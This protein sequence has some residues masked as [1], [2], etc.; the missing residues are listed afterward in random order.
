M[1]IIDIVNII[2]LGRAASGKSV[3]IRR[4]TTELQGI[5]YDPTNEVEPPTVA[6]DVVSV[7]VTLEG[8]KFELRFWDT[9]GQEKYS[10]LSEAFYRK[11][12]GV[13]QCFDVT[14]ADS[15]D[16][17]DFYYQQIKD[18]C[19]AETTVSLLATKCDRINERVI[20][21]ECG[22]YMAGKNCIDYFETSSFTNQN[23][24]NSVVST[25]RKVIERTQKGYVITKKVEDDH[26][27]YD[28][29]KEKTNSNDK[30]NKR[31]RNK[32]CEC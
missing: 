5:I 25:L 16:G 30:R 6:I 17:V 12:D 19:E 21:T 22:R 13:L 11:A 4:Y 14:D 31:F 32:K 24:A 8:K 9:V 29:L 20:S 1:G 26:S 27:I 23:I 18:K 7:I 2:V 15:Y 3:L 28:Q 10:A